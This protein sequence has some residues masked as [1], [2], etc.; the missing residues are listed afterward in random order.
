M[1]RCVVGISTLGASMGYL[2]DG[3]VGGRC[4]GIAAGGS[5]LRG[6]L[7]PDAV[8]HSAFIHLPCLPVFTWRNSGFE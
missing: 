5:T 1:L 6:N 7:R 2:T 4:L 3:W 8:I